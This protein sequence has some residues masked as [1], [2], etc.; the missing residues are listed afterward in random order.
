MSTTQLS[1]R[2]LLALG[3]AGLL[4]AAG[5][6]AGGTMALREER[7]TD[8][9]NGPTASQVPFQGA[10]QA[11]VTTPVQDRLQMTAFDVTASSRAELVSL[12]RDW[13][14]AAA[15]MTSGLPVGDGAVDGP[16][17]APPADTG[18]ALGLS[19]ARLT[20][21]VGFGPSLFAHPDQ[22][23]RFGLAAQR[24]DELTDLPRFR[25]DDLDPARCGGD[26]I[27]QACADDPQVAVHAIR[28]LA[29]SGFGRA[30]V[31]WSQ[32]GFGKTSSTTPDQETPRNL[33]GFK[34]G[35]ENIASDDASAQDHHI[36]CGHEA[37]A[38]LRGGTYLVARR[39]GMRIEAWDRE[40]LHGQEQIIGRT[41][42]EG[43]PLGAAREHDPVDLTALP[44]NS[45]VALAHPSANGGHAL[46]RRG[47]SY[48]DGSDGLGHLDAGLFFIAFC[49]SPHTQYVPLQAK[50]ARQDALAEY[51]VHTGSGLWA[52][53]PGLVTSETYWGQSLLEG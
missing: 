27:V 9:C 19:P 44:A 49:R 10:H 28:N 18:E 4:T 11:G 39:I 48:V 45:H 12:L 5:A 17:Q 8:Q 52:C 7:R 38:W 25:G 16:A 51:L 43:A 29:R 14:A 34:D 36:W 30:A 50:L 26:L 13:T 46:L 37:P 31:R 20:I 41:K 53:P 33:F 47:Y 40:S 22:G 24:P 1:R 3:G 35:T 6:G 32:L 23:D 21:T 2:R 42:G 15:V